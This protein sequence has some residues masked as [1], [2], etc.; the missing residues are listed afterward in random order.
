MSSEYKI[1]GLIVSNTTIS[2]PNSLQ[3]LSKSE[4]GGLSGSP[5]KDLSTQA[6]FD[7]YK[8]TNGKVPII[9]VGGVGSG[10]D[11]YEKIAAGASL[12]QLYTS[13]VYIGPPVASKVNNELEQILQKKGFSNLQ[14]AIGSAHA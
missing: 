10:Q 8:L 14:Q 1:D 11:A 5:L 3:N 2:R 13:F 7:M 4:T 9:G 6:I 12:I